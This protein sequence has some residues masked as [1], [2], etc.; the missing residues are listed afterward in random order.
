MI[1][2][3]ASIDT[4][5]ELPTVVDDVTPINGALLNNLRDAII[6]VEKELGIKPSGIYGTIRARFA[7]LEVAVAAI[8]SG[9]FSLGGDLAGTSGSQTVIGLQ[10]YPV[11]STAP[12]DGYLLTWDN[13]DGYWHPA[14]APVGFSAG[15]DLS[16]TETNQTV[17][18]IQ[19]IP[20]N[21]TVPSDG[22]LL[23]Y[24]LAD[25]YWHPAPAP[26]GFSAGGDLIGS[27][28][29]QQVV[30]LTGS[31]GIVSVPT[32]SIA[33]GTI[34]STTGTIRLA[35][36][37]D[38]RMR[39]IGNNNDRVMMMMDSSN[40]MYIGTDPGFTTTQPGTM[41]LAAGSGLTIGIATAQNLY[42][43]S[44]TL[45]SLLPIIG[46]STVYGVHG[47]GEQAMADTNQTPANTVYCYNTIK[48]TG[49]IT[50]NKTLTLPTATDAAG[51]TKIIN[52]TCT[53]AFSII[54]SVGAGTTATI[55]NGYSATVLMD[56]RG[57]TLI[58][59]SQVPIANITAGTDGY[60]ISTVAGVPTW[61]H[62]LPARYELTL[63][64]G[65]FSTTSSTFTRSGG[66]QID[67]SVFPAT[68]GA[69]TRSVVFSAD[70]DMTAGAT[71]VE[72]QLYDIT[73]SVAV[74]S[75]DL[76]SSSTTNTRVVSSALTVG[77][78]AGNIRS[79]VATQYELQFK[80]NGGGGSDAVFL[81]NSRLVVTYA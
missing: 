2:Y 25:G 31:A 78:S 1:K 49:A 44:A 58:T 34:P 20:V 79:D 3:P 76:T 74:T 69:L 52:N 64:S 50:A 4:S 38:I 81:T 14:P 41:R 80:M 63:A 56:S 55:A 71:T 62:Q 19:N 17:I 11:S 53:G 36:N 8:V 51:Y 47:V 48:T 32:A 7:A 35:N 13:I 77:S 16:G 23:T 61:T 42:M 46:R 60:V 75:T 15:T 18:G 39:D 21:A 26:I 33:F 22:Y 30:S 68:I 72:V 10:T 73:H 9:T 59:D 28:S 43:N 37:S 5:I 12:T 6:A 57:V 45:Q 40:E 65:L 27:A 29:S 66:R 24:D 54:V 70:I 67:M